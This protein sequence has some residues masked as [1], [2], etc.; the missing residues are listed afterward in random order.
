MF[1]PR[2]DDPYG[3]VSLSALLSWLG[4]PLDLAFPR[5]EKVPPGVSPR[6]W[7]HTAEGFEPAHGL[8]PLRVRH[9]SHPGEGVPGVILQATQWQGFEPGS[10]P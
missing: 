2:P 8:P 4:R 3:I 9:P 5:L 7:L 10:F 6:I 1:F